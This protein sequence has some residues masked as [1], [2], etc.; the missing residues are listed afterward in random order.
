MY[1]LSLNHNELDFKTI[2]EEI[3]KVVC[4][5]ACGIM[6]DVLENIDLRLLASR[7]TSKYRNKGFRK[8]CIHTL[9]GEVEYKRR[10]Y[11]TK[12]EN[13]KNIHL[14][15]LDKFLNNETVGHV[16]SNLAEK[17]VENV[18]EQSYR[19]AAANIESMSQ[20]SLSHTAIWNVIQELGSRLE[21][22]EAKL[23][24]QYNQGKINGKE[25]VE[26]LFHEADGIWLNMQGKDR[27]KNRKSSKKEMKMAKLY[28]G[29]KERGNQK[30]AYLTHNP[31]V[32]ASYDIASNFKKL[33]DATIAE[34]YNI[35]EIKYRIING[36][37]ASWIKR[38]LDEEGVHYQLDPFHRAREVVRAVPEKSDVKK[39]NNMF[40]KGKVE[41][42]IEYLVQLM[43]EYTEDEKITKK[44]QK[45]Y[46]YLHNNREGLIPYKLR[47][48]SLPKPPEGLTYRNMGTMESS[49]CDV[50]KLR[51]KGRK[52][53]WT[54]SGANSLGKLLALR[55]SGKLY[56]ELNILFNSRLSYNKA[57]EIVEEV[58]QL[59]AAEA[60]KKPK[61]TGIYPIKRAPMPYEG[62]SM[63]LG[64]KAIRDLTENR[65]ELILR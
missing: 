37:G 31:T 36:D 49:V 2:E 35:D 14:Y 3:Y 58:V 64:R 23:I 59:S 48:I 51:M 47:D 65:I 42:G 33:S 38:G 60:N 18:L 8:T 22:Q 43:V 29:W 24:N 54:K 7:D 56:D 4:E 16:S 52:M 26:V 53:S 57:E 11:K 32:I 9:M 30:N 34:K 12:D 1:T 45:L 17:I 46:T 61:R 62:Q 15:L 27:S 55:A 44:L 19:K 50:I 28:E 39:L 10:I 40:D 63:T 20:S 5:V 41:E 6:K 25:E 21:K 13:G